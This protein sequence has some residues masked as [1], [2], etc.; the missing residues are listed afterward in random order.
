MASKLFKRIRR[1][2]TTDFNNS[3]LA[4]EVPPPYRYNENATASTFDVV[5]PVAS[6]VENV[7]VED[8]SLGGRRESQVLIVRR[9]SEGVQ[10]SS[11][12]GRGSLERVSI[13]GTRIILENESMERDLER[14]IS[15]AQGHETLEGRLPEPP[16]PPPPPPSTDPVARRP[17]IPF[18]DIPPPPPPPLPPKELP[19]L[20]SPL[21]P[22]ELL[23]PPAPLPPKELPGP[24]ASSSPSPNVHSELKSIN[25]SPKPE[26]IYEVSNQEEDDGNMS[27]ASDDSFIAAKRRSLYQQQEVDDLNIRKLNITDAVEKEQ[28]GVAFALLSELAQSM[29]ERGEKV[30]VEWYLELVRLSLKANAV[31]APE[32]LHHLPSNSE[33]TDGGNDVQRQLRMQSMIFE[34]IIARKRGDEKAST[35]W[36]LKGSKFARKYEFKEEM[37]ICY[38]M[39]KKLY[40]NSGD[41]KEVELYGSLISPA[42]YN[43]FNVLKYLNPRVFRTSVTAK[44]LKEDECLRLLDELILRK[45]VA[46]DEV[47]RE[48]YRQILRF[49]SVCYKKHK[50]SSET[51]SGIYGMGKNEVFQMVDSA[52]SLFKAPKDGD[53][54]VEIRDGLVC[55]IICPN[56]K[57]PAAMHDYFSLDENFMLSDLL[58]RLLAVLNKSLVEDIRKIKMYGTPKTEIAKQHQTQRFQSS[59]EFACHQWLYHFMDTKL[60]VPLSELQIFV[61]EHWLHWIELIGL[62]GVD[63]LQ[64]I[65][66]M[67]QF[68]E[69]NPAAKRRVKGLP[70]ALAKKIEKLY[71]FLNR[72]GNTIVE[73]PLQVYYL[74]KFFEFEENVNL[75][76][77][78]APK[79]SIKIDIY[80]SQN[81][82]ST[83]KKLEEGYKDLLTVIKPGTNTQQKVVFSSD[84]RLVAYNVPNSPI[85]IVKD[86]TRKSDGVILDHGQKRVYEIHFSP[87]VSEDN[88]VAII[89]DPTQVML[90]DISNATHKATYY[91]ELKNQHL[92]IKFSPD[93]KLIAFLYSRTKVAVRRTDTGNEVWNVLN[94]KSGQILDMSF[95]HDSWV[96]AIFQDDGTIQTAQSDSDNFTATHDEVP[97]ECWKRFEDASVQFLNDEKNRILA[98]ANNFGV[99]I[100]APKAT[101]GV[102]LES[103]YFKKYK[104]TVVIS[105]NGRRIATI[106]DTGGIQ[107]FDAE[108]GKCIQS[109]WRL[110]QIYRETTLAAAF[111]PSGDRLITISKEMG[112][113]VWELTV[114]V[115]VKDGW[116]VRGDE[117]VMWIPGNYHARIAEVGKSNLV[118]LTHPSGRVLE[119]E[120]GIDKGRVMVEGGL[121]GLVS[122]VMAYLPSLPKGLPSIPSLPHGLPTFGWGSVGQTPSSSN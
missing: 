13:E 59:L 60:A 108:T 57:S 72:Y 36:F 17:S 95:R 8:V 122:N 25:A 80:D 50:I 117:K 81:Q 18:R 9:G 20:P 92:K 100:S 41:D 116:V 68:L 28:W 111:L 93:G 31:L 34:G 97:R 118:V 66:R 99:Q 48:K 69:N 29:E 73:T 16:V 83:A 67:T 4:E 82:D 86:L 89:T 22:K 85:V 55:Y 61:E 23:E 15:E 56:P 65:S 84:L 42:G 11:V 43:V 62:L 98:W 115:E 104:T 45:D 38:W 107:I 39:L 110:N 75:E 70:P 90:W 64:R 44:S 102:V 91:P 96:L 26:S 74:W 78:S 24:P 77:P 33:D 71:E 49:V 58:Q 101:E 94:A 5:K 79:V 120:F 35:R 121:Y 2:P 47:K 37:T 103:K 76:S 6:Y 30:P 106:Q 12:I 51:I 21:P 7:A 113:R 109:F 19:E 87:K 119:V 105:P 10:E 112:M 88:I 32:V 3:R 54:E 114:D 14:R 63:M 1:K 52:N 40:Q 27:D 46:K 53:S